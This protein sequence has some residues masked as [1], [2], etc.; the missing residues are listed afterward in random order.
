MAT[1]LREVRAFSTAVAAT[2]LASMSENDVPSLHAQPEP[3]PSGMRTVAVI[4]TLV[5]ES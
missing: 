2:C 5:L 4:V 1:G 3:V